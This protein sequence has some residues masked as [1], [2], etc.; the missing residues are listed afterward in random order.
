MI[1]DFRKCVISCVIC[2]QAKVTSTLSASAHSLMSMVTPWSGLSHRS[3]ADSLAILA[4]TIWNY[5][6]TIYLIEFNLEVSLSH[7]F[8]VTTLFWSRLHW[9]QSQSGTYSRTLAH[10]STVQKQSYTHSH[11]GIIY[12]S[13]SIYWHISER[14]EETHLDIGKTCTESSV[15]N[16]VTVSHCPTQH[17]V[18]LRHTTPFPVCA[19]KPTFCFPWE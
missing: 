19:H 6:V 11:L 18:S 17:C 13:Q 2:T 9:I 5:T 16:P 4:H 10:R 8:S 1:R 12:L 3:V 15:S 14:W 7:S